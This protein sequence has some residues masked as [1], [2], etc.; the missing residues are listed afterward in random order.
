MIGRR[1]FS[2]PEKIF[3][4]PVFEVVRLDVFRLNVTVGV[5]LDNRQSSYEL[6]GETRSLG[7][8]VDWLEFSGKLMFR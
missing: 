8:I 2:D 6:R 3:G 7:I 1:Q 4:W 5:L